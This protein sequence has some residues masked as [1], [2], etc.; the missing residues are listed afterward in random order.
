MRRVPLQGACK[1]FAIRL[2]NTALRAP[3]LGAPERYPTTTLGT[4]NRRLKQCG[5]VGQIAVRDVGPGVGTIDIDAG[6][7][8]TERSIGERGCGNDVLSALRLLPAASYQPA[9][10]PNRQAA[11]PGAPRP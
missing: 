2:L 8:W 6:A 3:D 9:V 5:V 7:D 4:P 11:E 1:V 10:E